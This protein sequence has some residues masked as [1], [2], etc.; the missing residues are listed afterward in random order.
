[1]IPQYA[2]EFGEEERDAVNTY[3][4]SGGWLTEHTETELFEEEF[5]KAVG[6]RWASAVNNGTISLS[7]ALLG[8][9]P[10]AW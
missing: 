4:A 10:G 2:P 8:Y 5:A 7:I 1:V 3:M 9:G 6:A